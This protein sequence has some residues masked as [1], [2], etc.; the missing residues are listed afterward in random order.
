MT[1]P[2]TPVDGDV[3]VQGTT[4]MNCGYSFMWIRNHYPGTLNVTWGFYNLCFNA[5]SYQWQYFV[6]NNGTF[7]RSDGGGGT[8]WFRREVQKRWD[9][10]HNG[11][12]RQYY[13]GCANL[14]AQGPTSTAAGTACDSFYV[15]Q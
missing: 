14:W 9:G 7:F 12:I 2:I 15:S 6:Q 1:M 8:L 4:S 11:A 3:T 10:P 5:T 13:S